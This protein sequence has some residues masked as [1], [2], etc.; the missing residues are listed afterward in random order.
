MELYRN[1]NFKINFFYVLIIY[2]E[3]VNY[4]NKNSKGATSIYGT[5]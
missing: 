4:A 2:K 5:I 1:N 3:G